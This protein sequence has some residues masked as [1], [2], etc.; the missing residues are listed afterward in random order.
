MPADSLSDLDL[1][2][3]A[4]DPLIYLTNVSW[5]LTFG[6]PALT[7]VESTRGPGS[8]RAEIYSKDHVLGFL[9]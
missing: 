7:F 8:I 6:D 9:E 1:L 4:R 3:I 2:V 5:L